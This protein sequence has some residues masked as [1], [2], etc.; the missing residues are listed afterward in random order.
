MLQWVTQK[1]DPFVERSQSGPND[2]AT[3]RVAVDPMRNFMPEERH[4][5]LRTRRKPKG[6]PDPQHRRP[7]PTDDAI[8][9]VENLVD[10]DGL[11]RLATQLSRN[12]IDQGM[13]GWKGLPADDVLRWRLPHLGA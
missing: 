13:Q 11:D 4:A 7:A 9:C 10:D 1:G 12:A 8:G 5:L 6:Q 2:D 3:G